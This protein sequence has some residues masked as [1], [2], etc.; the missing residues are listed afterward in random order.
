MADDSDEGPRP[1]SRNPSNAA[2][3][4][5]SSNLPA[6]SPQLDFSRLD[7]VNHLDHQGHHSHPEPRRNGGDEEALDDSSDK[8]DLTGKVIQD[9]EG[10]GADE[11][12]MPEVRDGRIADE[13]A[14]EAGPR[15]E[16]SRTSTSG[17]SQRDPN[18]VTWDSPE[19]PEN[20]KNWSMKRKWAATVVG[21][22]SLCASI[23]PSS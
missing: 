13:K 9:I 3:T 19:D 14:L 21:K 10:P 11:E 16:K 6:L 7:S 22:C 2:A 4:N 17:K 23:L 18:L 20:P 8:A 12:V 5:R 15:S 1:W